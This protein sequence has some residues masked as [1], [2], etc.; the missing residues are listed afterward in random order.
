MAR[1]TPA[2]STCMQCPAKARPDAVGLRQHQGQSARIAGHWDCIRRELHITPAPRWRRSRPTARRSYRRRL[3]RSP[4]SCVGRYCGGR[5]QRH[6]PALGGGYGVGCIRFERV[7]VPCLSN[8]A[9]VRLSRTVGCRKRTDSNTIVGNPH[10]VAQRLEA[11]SASP[12]R[13]AGHHLGDSS[14][15]TAALARADRPAWD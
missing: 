12:A 15:K 6:R 11:C 1:T 14:P 2:S 7:S 8:P 4:T 3:C 5:R 10:E 13:R 9:I